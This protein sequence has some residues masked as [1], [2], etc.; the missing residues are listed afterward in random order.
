MLH[1]WLFSPISQVGRCD[2]PGIFIFNRNDPDKLFIQTGFGLHCNFVVKLDL[3]VLRFS[4]HLR[5]KENSV[6]W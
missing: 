2:E 6:G 5:G 3:E 1:A 4:E